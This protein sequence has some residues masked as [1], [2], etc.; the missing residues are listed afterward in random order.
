MNNEQGIMNDEVERNS[1]FPV[2]YSSVYHSLPRISTKA[3]L[4][5]E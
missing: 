1:I 5:N 2:G 4:N 3:C